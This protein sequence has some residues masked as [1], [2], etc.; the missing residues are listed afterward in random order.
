MTSYWSMCDVQCIRS[1]SSAGA[2]IDGD[3]SRESR[4]ECDLDMLSKPCLDRFVDSASPGV[5]VFRDM[6]LRGANDFQHA[7]PP[8]LWRLDD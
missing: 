8:A 2:A 3:A 7:R 6:L 4:G 5:S 1:F